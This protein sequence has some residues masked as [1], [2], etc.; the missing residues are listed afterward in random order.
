MIA[1]EHAPPGR[2]VVS[3]GIRTRVSRSGR[4]GD[5][6]PRP[7]DDEGHGSS[8]RAAGPRPEGFPSRRAAAGA[9]DPSVRRVPLLIVSAHSAHTAER[10]DGPGGPRRG[11][12][13]VIVS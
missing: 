12:V 10:A 3:T 11:E 7:L 5:G 2:G 1:Y 9:V 13:M 8:V 6:C 4:T